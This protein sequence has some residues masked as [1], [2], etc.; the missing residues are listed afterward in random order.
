VPAGGQLRLLI[1]SQVA[2]AGLLLAADAWV[3]PRHRGLAVGTGVLAA[4]AGL[5][6][7][8]PS[9]ALDAYPTTYLRP[10]I[11][12][13]CG[14]I[15]RGRA[16]YRS[17]CAECHGPSGRG[18][19]PRA[20]A[21]GKPPADLAAAHTAEHT[22]GDL[23]WWLTRGLPASGMPGFGSTLS[24]AERWDLV[25]FLRALS[26]AFAARSLGAEVMPGGP[27][28][29]A[30]DFGWSVG[31]IP[32][33]GLREFRGRQAVLLVL[34]TLPASRERLV[35]LAGRHE[36]LG[37]LGVAVVAVPLGGAA[38]VIR[39]LGGAPAMRFP[40]VT[41]GAEEIVATYALFGLTPVP[42]GSDPRPPLPTHM[43]LLV[44]RHGYLRGRWIPGRG[45]GTG[46]ADLGALGAALGR[47]RAEAPMAFAATHVH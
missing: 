38:G 2:V 10:A 8:L 21:L 13:E 28:I 3:L 47:L 42:G 34:F 32:G 43:E 17:R 36:T 35:Q 4:A 5:G 45:G 6:L 30:P 27:R 15:A 24:Q 44:D 23:F 26:D 1:G 37:A 9:M 20:A 12:Y 19:G 33:Q 31:P 7:A 25:N 29:V 22:A 41:G 18:D 11:P 14:S 39:R 16:L 40:V 46:W